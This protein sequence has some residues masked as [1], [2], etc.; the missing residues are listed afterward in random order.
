M[1][2]AQYEQQ[3][4]LMMLPDEVLMK[5]MRRFHLMG[6]VMEMRSCRQRRRAQEL[7]L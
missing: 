6:E 2:V 3:P 4:Q 7:Q 1:R 5:P